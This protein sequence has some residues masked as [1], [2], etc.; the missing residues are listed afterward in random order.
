MSNFPIDPDECVVLKAIRDSNSLREAA[1]L[2]NCDPAGLARRVQ[3]ISKQTGY[4]QKVSNHWRVTSRGLDLVIWVEESIEAQKKILAFKQTLRIASTTW[5]SEEVVVPNLNALKNSIGEGTSFSFTVP[6]I[7][8][9]QSLTHGIV[10]FVIVCHAPENPEIEHRQITK[11]EW[12]VIVPPTWEKIFKDKKDD[13][14]I[15]DALSLKPLLRHSSLN[16]SSFMPITERQLDFTASFDNLISIRACVREGLGWSIVPKLLVNRDLKDK[17][18]IQLP[19]GLHVQDR[20]VCVWWLRNRDSIKQKANKLSS[21]VK[22]IC[23]K[24]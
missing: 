14:A 24:L 1:F 18:V 5:F 10:D 12:I 17:K 20:K 23:T 2:L 15:L 3:K 21:A 4:L 6:E 13:A 7:S 19:Y 16:L 8:F 22:E 9:E 11:E